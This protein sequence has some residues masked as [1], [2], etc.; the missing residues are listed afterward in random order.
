[1]DF[2]KAKPFT[3]NSLL[4]PPHLWYLIISSIFL[5]FIILTFFGFFRPVAKALNTIPLVISSLLDK[6]DEVSEKGILNTNLGP[7][8]SEKVSEHTTVSSQYKLFDFLDKADLS[9]LLFIMENKTVEELSILLN[10][11]PY[12]VAIYLTEK[13]YPKST[14]ALSLLK[15]IN[16]V[17][18][19]KVKKLEMEL[20]V[21]LDF[22]IGGEDKV[23]SII[24]GVD[25]KIQDG[26]V[27]SILLY[28][29][30]N[31]S[32]LSEIKE[33][34]S[35]DAQI[36]TRRVGIRSIA[37]AIKGESFAEEFVSKLTEG[38]KER[39]LEDINNLILLK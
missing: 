3:W 25:E 14:E 18:A 26:I 23:V 9:K 7:T 6:K 5:L 29:G 16:I 24:E 20:R 2:K 33:L 32:R 4:L 11:A 39:L 38:M 37:I 19:E 28:T 13:L 31:I 1:M 35:Q 36:L 12:H 8:V 17:P 15:K 22:V 30:I 21:A 27:S 10:Y 34:S